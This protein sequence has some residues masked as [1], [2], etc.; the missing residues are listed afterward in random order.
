MDSAA[1]TD[2]L[3]R[4]A[5]FNWLREQVDREGPVLPRDLLVKGFVFRDSQ[6]R[7][8]G[9]QGIFK[10]RIMRLPI[11]I[12][13]VAGGP[14]ADKFGPT[15]LKYRYRGSDISHRDNAGLRELMSRREPLAYF[16]G[17]SEGRYLAVWPVF[18][19]G[20]DP[21]ALT[22]S[23]AVD[24]AEIAVPEGTIHDDSGIAIRRGYVT[25]I[26][27][28]RIHQEAFRARV[29]AAYRSQC[30]FCRLKHAELLD[31]AH[32]VADSQ[33]D[34]EPVVTNGIALCKL[35]HAAFDRFFLSVT[36]DY[37]VDIRRDVL[38][39]HD[40]PMLKHGLQGLHGQRIQLPHS[41]R[42]KPDRALLEARH[43]RFLELSRG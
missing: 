33:P 30:A 17:I 32:I 8:V 7:L 6:V 39:E 10:P 34:G 23:I 21:A 31:A 3:V 19:V 2:A 9:P 38:D 27:K 4:Q 12:T 15:L 18:V 22:F 41:D 28:R 11:S 37:V 26:V 40:G 1:I 29:I 14:Y 24:D 35:H 13:A 43:A 16:H 20:D 5:A 36:P 42:M 25:A